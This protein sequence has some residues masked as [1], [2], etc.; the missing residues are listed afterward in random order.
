MVIFQRK[1]GVK[2]R[3]I[4]EW[5]G[6]SIIIA[7]KNDTDNLR[8][9]LRDIMQ[10][11]YP[12]FEVIVID[13]HSSFAEK[14]LLE[15]LSEELKGL[16]I[17][18]AEISGKKNALAKGVHSAK[19]DTILCTD[20][21]CKPN[22]KQWIR[23]M[24]DTGMKNEVVLGYSPYMRMPGWLNLLIRY[25]TV[26]TAIQYMSWT[27]AGKPYMG[28]GRNMLYPRS[29]FLEK[30]PY[31]SLQEIPY[32]DDDLWVQI[33]TLQTRVKVCDD[34]LAHM[35]T[36]P[37]LTWRQWFRQKHRHLSAGHYYKRG[38]WWQPGAYGIS[39]VLHLILIPLLVLGSFWWKWVPVFLIGL[40][41]RWATYTLW[42]QRLGDR[43]TIPWY[44]LL[45]INYAIYLG[46]M[47]LY[48][49]IN[50]RKTWN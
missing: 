20:A 29:L 14:K 41:I 4:N 38:L 40:I 17:L 27:K 44:P 33:L 16:I 8:Q 12:V 50:N 35:M 22:S 37:P 25:E 31:K 49:G 34:P 11:D 28:V 47:G 21:D 32:G 43:D 18:S 1:P 48:T 45:E 2:P 6:I 19:Y 39:L 26:M 7:H 3:F 46:I 30:D 24:V 5:P 9:N 36:L 15:D 23:K 13:D 10:Q 42:T